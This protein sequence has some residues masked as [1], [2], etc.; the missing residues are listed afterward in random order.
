MKYVLNWFFSNPTA[1]VTILSLIV[2][3]FTYRYQRN[4]NRKQHTKDVTEWY[5][6]VA[7]PQI[8]YIM[9][10]L[11]SIGCMEII[12]KFTKFEDF[13]AK[14]LKDNLL[15]AAIKNSDFTEKFNKITKDVLNNAFIESGCNE[16]IY[17]CHQNLL[18]A[19]A[20]NGQLSYSIFNKF[21]IDFL[22]EVELKALQLNYYIYDEKMVYPILHQTFLKN[23]EYLYFFIASENTQ[24]YDQFYI[25]T[26]W[27]Y[28]LWS[29]RVKKE[30]KKLKKKFAQKSKT[31]KV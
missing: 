21:I 25:Y 11:T 9:N 6:K 1:F 15:I 24:D 17:H 13:D 27:L 20:I 18:K 4:W 5:A 12:Q 14:E 30:K 8:R 26:I 28:N 2:A 10:V 7:L 31:S 22:N 16:Y 3:F 19:I 29:K 23:I